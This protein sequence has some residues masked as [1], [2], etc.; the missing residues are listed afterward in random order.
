MDGSDQ[1]A[2]LRE[3]L[4]TGRV[5][6]ALEALAPSVLE[7]ELAELADAEASDRIS[8]HV[9]R[10]LAQAIDAAPERER[11]SEGIRLAREVL[12]RLGA[13]AKAADLSL[14]IPSEPAQ[15]LYAL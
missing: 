12:Q 8:R 10:L 1:R 7:P 13:V 11:T 14:D 9:A 15:V 5:E 3:A 4:L 6:R 2:G